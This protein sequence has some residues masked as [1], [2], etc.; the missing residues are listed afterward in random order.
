[1]AHT[2]DVDI[3][4]IY[5]VEQIQIPAGLP[6]MLKN[7]AKEAI[8]SQPPHLEEFAADYFS[9]LYKMTK[10]DS[11]APPPTLVQVFHMCSTFSKYVILD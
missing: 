6:E 5:C 11:S 9:L 7:F 3:E 10:L 4:P 1:M 2:M 8:R